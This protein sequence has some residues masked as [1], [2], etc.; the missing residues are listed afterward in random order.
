MI[1]IFEG[2]DGSGKSTQIELLH[3]HLSQRGY[4]SIVVRNPT[5][6]GMNRPN[7]MSVQAELLWYVTALRQ[8]DDK[9]CYPATQ[10]GTVV[11]LDRGFGS[12]LAYQ[13]YGL[14]RIA[15]VE[16]I[17]T[18]NTNNS[19]KLA[20]TILLHTDP[21]TAEHRCSPVDRALYQR[22]RGEFMRNVAAGYLTLA[23]R[24]DWHVVDGNR[25]IVAVQKTIQGIVDALLL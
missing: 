13:G 8:I 6:S 16:R 10:N 4:R 5:D 7:S 15:P 17:V 3:Q 21:A 14:Q 9:I 11:L 1:I 19:I 18:Y 2:I 12:T 23:D 22:N 20:P 25:S 24:Y